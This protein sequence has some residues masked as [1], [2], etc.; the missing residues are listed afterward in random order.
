MTPHPQRPGQEWSCRRHHAPTRSK[1]SRRRARGFGPLAEL[2]AVGLI[3]MDDQITRGGHTA[4]VGGV[5]HHGPHEFAVST[6]T[7]LTTL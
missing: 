7:V 1:R 5:L 2:V 4:T 6:V 3:G